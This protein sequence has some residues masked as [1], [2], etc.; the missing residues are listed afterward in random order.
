MKKRHD[1]KLILKE[2]AC[3]WSKIESEE[4]FSIDTFV[5][6]ILSVEVGESGWD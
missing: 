4:T 1:V 2:N 6:I 5:S 3:K